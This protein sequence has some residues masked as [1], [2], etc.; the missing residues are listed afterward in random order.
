[1]I[2]YLR[3]SSSVAN[4]SSIDQTPHSCVSCQGSTKTFKTTVDLL[5]FQHQTLQC[6]E[7]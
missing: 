6:S 1:M 2:L 7:D 5:R 4:E 3:N